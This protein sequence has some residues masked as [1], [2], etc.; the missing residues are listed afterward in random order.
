MKPLTFRPILK[1]IRW[2]G[3]R[4]GDLL[5]KKIGPESDYA[6]SWELADHGVDQSIVAEGTHAGRTLQQ[7]L[8]QFG[9]ALLGQHA[10]LS[11]F[12]LLIK[13]LDA[14]DWLSL[15]VH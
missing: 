5:D 14:N 4:L 9:S 8:E 13:F 12:P 15:Q 6:E 3:R 11:Q 1:R 2:G 10:G 7:M